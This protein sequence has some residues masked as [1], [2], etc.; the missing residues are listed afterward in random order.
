MVSSSTSSRQCLCLL[1]TETSPPPILLTLVLYVDELLGINDDLAESVDEL[2]TLSRESGGVERRGV[3]KVVESV[4]D[5]LVGRKL[6]L[7]FPS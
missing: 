6:A 1:S 5:L 2:L 4:V 7:L 3:D